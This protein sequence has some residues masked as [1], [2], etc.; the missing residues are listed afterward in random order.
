[1]LHIFWANNY[2]IYLYNIFNRRLDYFLVSE[3][4]KYNICDNV[5]RKEVYG[6]DHCPVVLYIHI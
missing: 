2:L 5:I 6:S 4:I 3:R 1:M